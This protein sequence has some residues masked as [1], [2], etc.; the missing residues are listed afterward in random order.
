MK[1]S[2]SGGLV[3]VVSIERLSIFNLLKL[4]GNDMYQQL[5]ALSLYFVFMN[6][7]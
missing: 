3:Y 2:I 1:W 4:N 6:F 5:L 7:V